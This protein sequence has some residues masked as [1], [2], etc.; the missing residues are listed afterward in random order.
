ML[1]IC[2]LSVHADERW[3]FSGLTINGDDSGVGMKIDRISIGDNAVSHLNYSCPGAVKLYPMHTCDNA[4]IEFTVN[5]Q[6]YEAI[7]DTKLNVIDKQWVVKLSSTNQQLILNLASEQPTGAVQLKGFEIQNLFKDHQNSLKSIN[8][9]FDG[10]LVTDFQN[11]SAKTNLP[12]TFSQFNYEYSDDLIVADLSGELQVNFN[13]ANQTLNLDINM[14]AGEMLLDE[15]YVNFANY[16]VSIKLEL[17]TND[18]VNYQ[19]NLSIANKQSLQLNARLNIDDSFNWVLPM[20]SIDVFDSHHFNQNI[21]SSVLGIY[22]FGK[23]E[24][25]GGFKLMIK[26][27][28]MP[29]DFWKI[30]FNDYYVLNNNRKI[31]IDALDGV[32]NWH[33]NGLAE[34]SLINWDTLVLAGMP[35]SQAAMAFNFSEDHF[36]LLD[37]HDFPIFDGSIQLNELTVDSMFSSSVGMSLNAK[38]LPISLKQI[39]EKLGWPVM[40]GTISGDIPGMVKTGSVIEFLGAL[41]LS[42]LE[43]EMLI[44]N[45]SLERLFGVA[46]VIAA[47]VSFELFNLSLLT[48]AFGFGEITG[49]LSGVINQLR[50]TNWKTDRLDAQVY[51]VKTKGVKQ[52]ISQRAIENISSLGGIKG[53]ISKTFLR[54]FDDFSYQKIKLSCKLHNSVC[55]IGGLKNQNNQFVI[56][57]GG[58]IPKINIVGYIRTINWE[59]FMDRLLNANYNN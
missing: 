18:G 14:T 7:L 10:N 31:Q 44:E 52:T 15:L 50:I 56:V 23:T 24:M 53:A 55:L 47:D 2:S 16:P 12:I 8:G 36:K 11:L 5:Q 22:G 4:F 34:N 3:N 57:E 40:A 43:G 1:L 28:V 32:V 46:P 6:V 13:L 27:A 45:L 20:V 39:T 30:Q 25:S 42:V 19:A 33:R 9:I 54:F 26:S 58:G 38:V 37:S 49:R 17:T 59:E 48:E 29:F 35:I 41:K 21:L 51:T